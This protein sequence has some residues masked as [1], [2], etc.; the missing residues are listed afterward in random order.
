MLGGDISSQSVP[1]KGSAFL[2]TV[3]TGPLQGIR[4]LDGFNEAVRA[5]RNPPGDGTAPAR[6]PLCG[7][8]LLVEDGEDNRR[9][10]AFVLQQHGATVEI[11]ENGQI[12]VD[13]VVQ[14]RDAGEAFDCILMDMQMP[15]LDGYAAT[16]RLREMGFRTPIIALTAHAMIGDRELCREAGC[17]DYVTKPIDRKIL[18]T[19]V[20]HHM[21]SSSRGVPFGIEP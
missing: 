15:V 8:L 7:R 13:K 19:V 11:A 3:E 20:A 16:R 21:L 10:I 14:A 2:V 18:P 12:A 17:D 1:G 6:I 5:A 4:S 9:L